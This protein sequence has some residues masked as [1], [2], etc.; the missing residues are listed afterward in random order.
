MTETQRAPEGL[1]S[2]PR[3][4]PAEVGD[5]RPVSISARLG[6][7]QFHHSGKFRVLQIADIQDGTKVSKDTVS[8]IEASLD[9][10]RPDIVI[11]PATRLP[12]MIRLLPRASANAVGAKR[13][14]LSL[15]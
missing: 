9:A 11:F 6:H 2:K 5:H 3:I 1:L 13:R 8:L 14:F 12:A 15:H 10:T 4:K 7:L